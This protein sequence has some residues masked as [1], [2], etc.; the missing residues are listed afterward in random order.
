MPAAIATGLAAL[1]LIGFFAWHVVMAVAARYRTEAQL[2]RY[3]RQPAREL[4]HAKIALRNEAKHAIE[5]MRRRF[6]DM[7]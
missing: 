5:K 2:K 6:W 7:P 1:A 3:A 4:L